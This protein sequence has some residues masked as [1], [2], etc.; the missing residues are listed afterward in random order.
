MFQYRY[1]EAV[2]V[3][4]YALSLVQ[5]LKS[6]GRIAFLIRLCH[7][8]VILRAIGLVIVVAVVG[9]VHG[10]EG[11]RIGKV[12]GPSHA[13]KLEITGSSLCYL[14]LLLLC[15]KLYLDTKTSS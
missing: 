4:Q 13:G 12:C 6:G 3:Y 1:A 8:F 9:T 7:Q 10:K 5:Q 11:E 14:Y 15:L 2:V